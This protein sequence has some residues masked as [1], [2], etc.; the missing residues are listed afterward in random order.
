MINVPVGVS[1]PKGRV[2]V[3]LTIRVD[4]ITMV[5]VETSSFLTTVPRRQ[6]V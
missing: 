6:P 5:E 4:V 1:A 2:I 3:E